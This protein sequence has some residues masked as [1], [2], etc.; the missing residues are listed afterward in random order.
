MHEASADWRVLNQ[1]T[2]SFTD[3]VDFVDNPP[4]VNSFFFLFF[5]GG[6]GG[7]GMYRLVVKCIGMCAN[8]ELVQLVQDKSGQTCL[9]VPVF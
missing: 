3:E 6:R 1:P 9:L 4:T 5:G 8:L 7:L 2:F